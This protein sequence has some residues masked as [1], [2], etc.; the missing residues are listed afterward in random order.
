MNTGSRRRGSLE[1]G[2]CSVS[3]VGDEAER[4]RNSINIDHFEVGIWGRYTMVNCS[5]SG[6]PWDVREA[7]KIEGDLVLVHKG[8]QG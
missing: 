2:L 3:F 7:E 5:Y 1:A 4:L 6:Y 8:W